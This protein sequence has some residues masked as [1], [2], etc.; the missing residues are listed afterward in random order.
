MEH[1]LIAERGGGEL[2]P[3]RQQ[4]N[5]SLGLFQ[6]CS[7]RAVRY[8]LTCS[9]CS[10]EVSGMTFL[11]WVTYRKRLTLFYCHLVFSLLTPSQDSLYMQLYLH[12]L[13]LEEKDWERGRKRWTLFLAVKAQKGGEANKTAAK[14]RER[15]NEGERDAKRKC[16][17]GMLIK[18]TWYANNLRQG[19][20]YET[21]L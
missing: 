10:T 15:E 6:Y 18:V 1:A 12:V 14:K 2:A 20:C 11:S 21:P 9:P 8:L 13:L 19:K 4:K 16:G 5:K 3:M 17:K 7:L